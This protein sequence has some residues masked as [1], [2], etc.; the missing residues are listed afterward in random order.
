MYNNALQQQIQALEQLKKSQRR[1]YFYESELKRKEQPTEIWP[2]INHE[3]D[4]S[5]HNYNLVDADQPSKG[6]DIRYLT[7]MVGKLIANTLLGA[8]N[9][10][11]EE[12]YLILFWNI[13]SQNHGI[14]ETKSKSNDKALVAYDHEE[15]T[16]LSSDI[17]TLNVEEVTVKQEGEGN[18]RGD[19]L[20]IANSEARYPKIN[21]IIL[22]TNHGRLFFLVIDTT[23]IQQEVLKEICGGRI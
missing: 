21:H 15:T 5:S 16:S 11:I 23:K 18:I 8:L 14:G 12:K 1:L 13:F 4:D 7:H 2:I 22:Q 6:E 19:F 3:I 10:F 9:M 20:S 17:H